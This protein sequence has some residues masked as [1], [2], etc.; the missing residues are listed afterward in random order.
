MTTA[1]QRHTRVT[2]WSTQHT[3]DSGNKNS[4]RKSPRHQVRNYH[5]HPQHK[6]NPKL[7]SSQTNKHTDT[8]TN[9]HSDI[10]TQKHLSLLHKA[11]HAKPAPL[12]EIR[13]VS[14]D[15]YR[16]GCPRS[17]NWS[18]EP[19]MISVSKT[20]SREF[21]QMLRISNPTYN[22]PPKLSYI[23]NALVVSNHFMELGRLSDSHL[24]G[25]QTL[26]NGFLPLQMISRSPSTLRPVLN[27]LP[28][29]LSRDY[30]ESKIDHMNLGFS[31]SNRDVIV[32]KPDKYS[33][34]N[35]PNPVEFSLY[36]LWSIQCHLRTRS[37]Q[38]LCRY[39]Y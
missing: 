10:Q 30:P 4:R 11:S 6:V 33:I 34:C 18:W 26:L 3:R 13:C 1:T 20:P 16:A 22:R 2:S 35:H 31:Y 23:R 7:S 24:M 17:N 29:R 8:N 39:L 5:T 38:F 25:V 32:T 19:S 27:E 14:I 12:I 9:S 37:V 21:R 15:S 28:T 36:I